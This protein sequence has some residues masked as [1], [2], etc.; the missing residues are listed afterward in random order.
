[1]Y[2]NYDKLKFK[3]LK[4]PQINIKHNFTKFNDELTKRYEY[5]EYLYKHIPSIKVWIDIAIQDIIAG[6]CKV[7]SDNP[8][9]VFEFKKLIEEISLD[10][11]LK[12]CLFNQFLYGS[13]YLISE[14][15]KNKQDIHVINPHYVR[16]I[17]ESGEIK[18]LVKCDFNKKSYI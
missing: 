17:K 13:G 11:K 18:N 8:E 5:Y 16:S 12:K 15:S 9:I 2:D 7:E 1:M 6:G 4:V 10:L 14:I 3:D